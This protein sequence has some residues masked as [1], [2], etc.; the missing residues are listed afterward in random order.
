MR[1]KRKS[2]AEY[3]EECEEIFARTRALGKLQAK[4]RE[5]LLKIKKI[6]LERFNL[7][8]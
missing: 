6:I 5:R 4:D 7:L 2:V 8:N 1:K 3:N